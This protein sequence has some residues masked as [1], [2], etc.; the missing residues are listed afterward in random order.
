MS[1]TR[2]SPFRRSP[3]EHCCS[4]LPL[5]LHVLCLPLAFILS[6]DQTLHC[7]SFSFSQL[8]S[9]APFNPLK[10]IDAIPIVQVL[11]CTFLPAFQISHKNSHFLKSG[12]AKIRLL[13]L[14]PNFF[15]KNL[16]K[17]QN[18]CFSQQFFTL[19]QQ[20]ICQNGSV[21]KSVSGIKNVY[22]CIH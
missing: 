1:L 19:R 21:P 6:Q 18:S 16:T 9:R 13:S 14:P 12:T 4:P 2:Y 15:E 22:F 7:I 8:D 10:R 20:C 3:A 5:D 11:A 17:F